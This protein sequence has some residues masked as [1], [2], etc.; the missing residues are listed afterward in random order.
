M[1]THILKKSIIM[2]LLVGMLLITGCHMH[3]RR[4]HSDTGRF[5]DRTEHIVKTLGL[6][7]AQERKLEEILSGP[8]SKNAAH[9]R[10]HRLVDDITKELQKEEL[11]EVYLRKAT[12]SYLK[13]LEEASFEFVS[14][15][16]AFHKTLTS[17]QKSELAKLLKT[18]R[19]RRYRLSRHH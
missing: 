4:H 12:S 5:H 9:G 1:N 14:Q 17:E 19:G 6:N 10:G 3:D 8:E 16:A 13:E 18:R 7:Q 11:D 2:S 15:L